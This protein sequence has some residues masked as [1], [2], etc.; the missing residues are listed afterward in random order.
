MLFLLR[1]FRISMGN[2]N[3]HPVCEAFCV[4]NQ[5][6]LPYKNLP[7]YCQ[8]NA[9]SPHQ[10]AHYC[11]VPFPWSSLPIPS[12]GCQPGLLTCGTGRR[13][14]CPNVLPDLSL[15]VLCHGAVGPWGPQPKGKGAITVTDAIYQVLINFRFVFALAYRPKSGWKNGEGWGIIGI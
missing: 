12:V 8:L 3:S 2:T 1:D 11:W 14:L 10:F 13:I 5:V 15:P 9:V 6:S 4:F 7:N